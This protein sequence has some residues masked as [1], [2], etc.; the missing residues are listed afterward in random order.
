MAAQ[1]DQ[2]PTFG[3]PPPLARLKA[4]ASS[5]GASAI[6]Q[7]LLLIAQSETDSRFIG[8]IA[9]FLADEEIID[10]LFAWAPEN[11]HALHLERLARVLW[12][13][14]AL[15]DELRPFS[16]AKVARRELSR[17]RAR[18]YLP[19]LLSARRPLPA[20]DVA[21]WTQ[22]LRTFVLIRALDAL[23]S[24]YALE[25]NLLAVCR[26]VL[27]VCDGTDHPRRVLLK[28]LASSHSSFQDF[29]AETLLNCLQRETKRKSPRVIAALVNVLH[30]QKW[31]TPPGI[32]N[33]KVREAVVPTYETAKA[34]ESDPSAWA[35]LDS[36][37]LEAGYAIALSSKGNLAC[38][39]DD[40]TQKTH[41]LRKAGGEYLRL[42]HVEHSLFLRH[43][44]HH[45]SEGEERQVL[46][47][48]DELL[49]DQCSPVDR[50]GAALT[51]IAVLTSQSMYELDRLRIANG[52]SQGWVLDLT[53]GMLRRAPPR[54]QRRWKASSMAQRGRWVR[55][56]GDEWCIQ[57]A[58]KVAKPLLEARLRAK[59]AVTVK[60][61]WSSVG[62]TDSVEHWYGSRFAEAGPLRRLTGP[63]TAALLGVRV[64]ERT[65]D[66]VLARLVKSSTGAAL[67]GACAY[68]AYGSSEI[69]AGLK[70][71]TDCALWTFAGPE[72]ESDTNV[73]GSE[74]DL[75][76]GNLPRML[77]TLARR[78]DAA[79]R[80][81]RDW[82]V[83]HNELC[84]LT[85]IALLASTG[86]RPVSSPFESLAWFDLDRRLVYIEDK[87]SGPTRGSRVCVLSQ[88]AA[89]LLN[90]H[91]LP[92]LSRLAGALRARA[93][94]FAAEIDRQ[95]AR[96]PEA[97]LPLL[98]FVRAE[99]TFSWIE[100]TESQL[101]LVVKFDWPLPWNCFRHLHSTQLRR[102]GLHP[103]IRDA[104]LGHADRDAESHGYHSFRVPADDFEAAR[105]LVDRLQDE[106]G[107]VAPGTAAA[108]LQVDGLQLRSATLF[109]RAYGR[110]A[111]AE[112]RSASLA[113][114]R[115][116]ATRQIEAQLRG[117]NISALSETDLD[118][119]ARGML[120]RDDH[121][122]HP[123]ASVRYEV[124]EE[125]LLREWQQH[126]RRSKLG[127]RYVLLKEGQALFNDSVIAADSRLRM[128]SMQ[129]DSLAGGL[130]G[131]RPG[132]HLAAAVM[133]IDLVLQSRVTYL[134]ML[135]ALILGGVG[136]RATRL[137]GRDWLDWGFGNVL[138]SGQPTFRVGIS[139]RALAWFNWIRRAGRQ[140]QRLPQLPTALR[141]LANALEVPQT[142]FDLL[143]HRLVALQ[144]QSNAVSLPGVL[145]GY[146]AGARP[147]SALPDSDSVRLIRKGS[148]P[149]GEL[150]G[151]SS[152]EALVDPGPRG[153]RTATPA[154]PAFD[155]C[156]SLFSEVREILASA[157]PRE[158]KS[159]AIRKKLAESGFSPGDSPYL[160]AEFAIHLLHRHRLSKGRKGNLRDSTI[161][162]YWDSL[163]GRVLEA[164]HD[165]N[166]VELDCDEITELYI[167][168]VNIRRIDEEADDGAQSDD[169]DE[170][171]DA[172]DLSA[173]RRTALRL[174]EFHDY[175]SARYGVEDPDWSELAIGGA[176]LIGRPGIVLI[177]EYLA[178]LRLQ[179]G[180]A[181]VDRLGDEQI[182]R[183][184]ALIVC[185]RFGLRTAEAVG[186]YRR[187]VVDPEGG[188]LVVL[189]RSNPIRGLKTDRSRRH[190]PQ[191]EEFSDIE[192]RVIDEALR[193][194][195]HRH[196]QDADTP[197][198]PTTPKTFKAFVAQVSDDVRLVLKQVTRR[199]DATMH[200]LRHAFAMRVLSGLLGCGI[201]Q[202]LGNDARHTSHL[203]RLLLGTEGIDRRLLWAVSRLL[204]H[205][206]PRV[207]LYSYIN[208]LY[209][210]LP[211]PSSGKAVDASL[212]IN[213][214]EV[215]IDRDYLSRLNP[216]SP[217]P[218]TP[219]SMLCRYL[220]FL[221]L[222]VIGQA[223]DAAA[224]RSL[225][226]VD[227]GGRLLH[228]LTQVADRLA[229]D[230]KRQGVF[231]LLGGLYPRRIAELAATMR[232]MVTNE[233][234]SSDP[235]LQ[236]WL[237]TVGR[238]RQI[239]LCDEHVLGLFKAFVTSTGLTKKDV[240]LVRPKRLHQ[241]LIESVE[242]LGLSGHIRVAPELG[243]A[244]QLDVARVTLGH[245]K[246]ESPDRVVA[247]VA[248]G[249]R[250][251]D[252]FELM[253]LWAVY[254]SIT[255]R[256]LP[257]RT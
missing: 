49:A 82:V 8:A 4:L 68:G 124:F 85:A 180:G 131:R 173:S 48:V 224:R 99:P 16:A 198:F 134:P 216:A 181:A 19:V 72:F 70:S 239:V 39:I 220:R 94:E 84:A 9:A 113:A 36:A 34:D 106:L 71:T 133:A 1:P 7:R 66:H 246:L 120:F 119:I 109:E 237:D 255:C 147:S 207:T 250:L 18:R 43:T 25:A 80:S 210:W 156:R 98:F 83:H 44:W 257:E 132:R 103:D 190:V 191:V 86:A 149:I 184:F 90:K 96:D 178:A 228:E 166:L 253:T 148:M 163:A 142:D 213:L 229:D 64:F 20:D 53:A 251:K 100:V 162:R 227:D 135:R 223:V 168:I 150:A 15:V 128:L 32:A 240:W 51:L 12:T 152:E 38:L 114:A 145:A 203:R 47:R 241:S 222:V 56:L 107:F 256:A 144:A 170:V 3:H 67:P 73:C 139:S 225:I 186:L 143:L 230:P 108:S 189:V 234:D 27:P 231:K 160:L 208:C 171:P 57:L 201:G 202:E 65:Q 153:S 87:V 88:F 188:R 102:W 244:F 17:F 95:L 242:T 165:R 200:F 29:K 193:R 197:I 235:A 74:L 199:P 28:R 92:H 204:G 121:V 158:K 127:R 151:D 206:S 23:D 176:V 167:D 111:R 205:A 76:L 116:L 217:P 214:D 118:A 77:S 174:K 159:P 137:G 249:G 37:H 126:G 54:L 62:A 245:R 154:T 21:A 59:K 75:Q 233:Q 81:P 60:E 35:S 69:V 22:R 219:E 50:L 209:L 194:W 177:D 157:V 104:L 140:L 5:V 182:A 172:H 30:G 155:R 41:G 10:T 221:R 123:M 79:A 14:R 169:V 97:K 61:L 211:G 40:E 26:F 115:S 187:D 226:P 138:E 33:A 24:G 247:V 45:L 101:D 52:G 243:N 196:G 141:P 125:E 192:K 212:L 215:S 89:D 78:V 117:R 195:E 2:N 129:F 130:E 146:L 136:F 252:S 31:G 248:E 6:H 112:K 218:V 164:A 236:S 232:D 55:K 13:E 161:F 110:R 46:T 122:P 11:I 254:V 63:S 179:V 175:V 42:Q 238:S 183:A 185:A 105:P 91:Y 93:P 58:P